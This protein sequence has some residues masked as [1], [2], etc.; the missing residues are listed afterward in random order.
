MIIYCATNTATGKRYVGLTTKTLGVRQ[1]QHRRKATM[2]GVESPFYRAIRKHGWNAFSWE[3]LESCETLA[4]LNA[5]EKKWIRS[6]GS[7]I[8][9]HGYNLRDTGDV[10]A[11]F[12]KTISEQAKEKIRATLTGKR[13]SPERREKNRAAGLMRNERGDNLIPR[14]NCSSGVPG[15][16]WSDRDKRWCAYIN[17]SRKKLSLGNH[18]DFFEAVCARKS[19]EARL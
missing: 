2:H 8:N 5:A 6:L 16:S 13:H 15:V 10:H 18:K 4:D 3:V 19:A 12:R 1:G 7:M 14:K 17:P 11:G 9:Q